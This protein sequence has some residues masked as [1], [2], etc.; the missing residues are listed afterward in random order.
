MGGALP[1]NDGASGPYL[2]FRA[3]HGRTLYPDPVG[4]NHVNRDG[5]ARWKNGD[6]YHVRIWRD[7]SADGA[8][9]NTPE[10]FLYW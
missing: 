9:S 8:Y 7:S 1:P 6:E 4:A 10:A 2:P 3:N 5:S